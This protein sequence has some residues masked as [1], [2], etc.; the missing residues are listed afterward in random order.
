MVK[1]I[2]LEH[3]SGLRQILG[4]LEVADIADCP[5]HLDTQ[6]VECDFVADRKRYVLYQAAMPE[7]RRGRT[8]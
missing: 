4:R 6:P 5:K 8:A 2:V 7:E 1:R 3:A